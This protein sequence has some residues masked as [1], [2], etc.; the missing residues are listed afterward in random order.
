MSKKKPSGWQN[1]RQQL[2]VWTKLALI[3]LVKDLYDTSPDNRDFCKLG[4]RPKRPRAQPWKNIGT[5]SWNNSFQR[6]ALEN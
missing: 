1:I 6:V 3:A 2:N 4:F 5:K